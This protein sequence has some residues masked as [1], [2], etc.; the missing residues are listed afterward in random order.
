MRVAVIDDG[1]EEHD[2]M[3]GGGTEWLY[4]YKSLDRQWPSCWI[5]QGEKP[6]APR[7]LLIE[8]DMV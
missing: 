1:V 7:Q 5:V 6:W 2:D 3:A 4:A 8:W